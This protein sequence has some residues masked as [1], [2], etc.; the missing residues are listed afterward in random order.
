MRG[1][2]IW[3]RPIHRI[4]AAAASDGLHCFP[5]SDTS[6][7]GH[8]EE[9]PHFEQQFSNR[10]ARPASGSGEKAAASTPTQLACAIG[11]FRDS[12]L[13]ELLF[14]SLDQGPTLMSRI[15]SAFAIHLGQP[16][17]PFDVGRASGSYRQSLSLVLANV[18]G[19][20][21]LDVVA[22]YAVLIEDDGLGPAALRFF[23]GTAWAAFNQRAAS[24]SAGSN[25]SMAV[26]DLN[27]DGKPDIVCR[28]SRAF[29]AGSLLFALG[30]GDGT[31]VTSTIPTPK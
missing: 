8:C 13:R 27:G 7:Y 21:K 11:R 15:R 4:W 22:E 5:D 1:Q 25:G 10:L 23:W 26:G 17:R 29:P 28:F 16:D 9:H 3:T 18:N 2:L 6:P 20:G 31:F 14:V 30:E 12:G 19:D 24:H